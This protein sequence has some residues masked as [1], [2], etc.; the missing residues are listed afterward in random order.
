MSPEKGIRFYEHICAHRISLSSDA[1]GT[2]KKGVRL[3]LHICVHI[4]LK[5]PAGPNFLSF[6][7]AYN[8]FVPAY[9]QEQSRANK[10]GRGN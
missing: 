3:R 6:M 7:R 4:I 5:G 10:W 9:M 8:N 1:A 2:G